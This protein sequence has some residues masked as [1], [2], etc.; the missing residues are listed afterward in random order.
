MKL[1]SGLR[2]ENS[3]PYFDPFIESDSSIH[4][5]YLYNS[6]WTDQQYFSSILMS[7]YQYYSEM[8]PP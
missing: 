2:S 5:Y 7:V 4:S 6:L 3:T 8:G 1:A